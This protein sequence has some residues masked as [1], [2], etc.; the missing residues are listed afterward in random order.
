[1]RPHKIKSAFKSSG[2]L[3]SPPG[4]WTPPDQD[5]A[6]RLVAAG[7]LRVPKDKPEPEPA[8]ESAEEAVEPEPEPES[9]KKRSRRK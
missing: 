5:T 8:D 6:D 1:M 2:R 4:E 9:R 3:V 7:C